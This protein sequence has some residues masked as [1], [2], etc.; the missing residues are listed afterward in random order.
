MEGVDDFAS[1]ALEVGA[2]LSRQALQVKLI[3]HL[4]AT[5]RQ[6]F[7][8]IRDF[9]RLSEWIPGAR[10]SWSDD[11]NAEA[12]GQVGAVRMISTGFGRPVREVVK[13]FEAPRMIAYSATDDSLRGIYTD[14]LSVITCEPHP[15]GGSVM[16]WLAYAQPARN[17]AKRWLG[18]K[19]FEVTLHRAIKTLERKLQDR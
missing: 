19:V 3:R 17:P 9:E 10:K 1:Y 12:P 8:Y 11:T 7:D 18:K 15:A 5:Q 2:Q 4:D 16:V 6:L 14:H 13:A